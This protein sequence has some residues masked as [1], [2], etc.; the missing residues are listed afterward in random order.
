MLINTLNKTIQ[1]LDKL[2][3]LTKEDIENIKQAN[4]KEVFA[5]TKTKE[6]LASEFAK[7]KTEIDKILV[8]RNKP[9]EEIFSPEEEKLFN[10]FREKLFEFNNLHKRFSKLAL[11]VAN[12]YNTLL[13]QIHNSETIDYKNESYKDSNLQLKA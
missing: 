13:K 8:S 4:H 1:T 3:S 10:E 5:N 7:L 12:F 6:I 11:S 9:L 2:I